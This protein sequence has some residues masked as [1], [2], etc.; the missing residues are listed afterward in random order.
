MQVRT[1]QTG[2][3]PWRAHQQQGLLQFRLHPRVAPG[4]YTITAGIA[5]RPRFDGSF[6]TSLVRRQDVVAFAVLDRA[7]APRWG[8]VI[9]LQ[10]TAHALT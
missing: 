10:A 2:P 8:G 9:D 1:G 3:L 5:D 7:G 6:E 4:S